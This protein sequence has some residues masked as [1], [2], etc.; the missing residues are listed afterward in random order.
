MSR[1]GVR[2]SSRCIPQTSRGPSRRRSAGPASAL[3]SRWARAPQQGPTADPDIWVLGRAAVTG[4]SQAGMDALQPHLAGLA[5]LAGG[6]G[7]LRETGLLWNEP[8]H[9]RVDV[10]CL[11]FC[12]L[13]D[14]PRR[15]YALTRFACCQN[16]PTRGGSPGI[17]LRRYGPQ[18][19][20]CWE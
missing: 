18:G 10:V 2:R 13:T 17:W 7:P 5:E 9:V 20:H 8:D 14:L 4:L 1:D 11:I 12:C 3:L 19:R 15:R 16:L 6:L